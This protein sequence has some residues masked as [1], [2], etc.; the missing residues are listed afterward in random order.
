MDSTSL[1]TQPSEIKIVKP[2]WVKAAMLGLVTPTVFIFFLIGAFM[3]SFSSIAANF[4]F[5][6][7][8]RQLIPIVSA[9]IFSV[10]LLIVI[11]GISLFVYLCFK[12]WGVPQAKRTALN[13]MLCIAAIDCWVAVY[14]LGTG[15]S[16]IIV[17]ILGI[18]FTLLNVAVSYMELGKLKQVTQVAI[19]ATALT[20]IFIGAHLFMKA[21]EK[22]LTG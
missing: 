2:P 13:T 21:G 17:S 22:A 18:M 3:Y 10:P 5:I 6:I 1:P 12:A 9:I 7:R 16:E 14:D 15:P 19:G 8:S 11:G 20:A 4:E